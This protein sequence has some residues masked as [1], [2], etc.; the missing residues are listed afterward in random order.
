MPATKTAMGTRVRAYTRKAPTSIAPVPHRAAG[1]VAPGVLRRSTK[2]QPQDLRRSHVRVA[3]SKSWAI[4]EGI[5]VGLIGETGCEVL[6]LRRRRCGQ[7]I[8]LN[9]RIDGHMW[10]FVVVRVQTL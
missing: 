7:R 10:A 5:Q 8:H 6:E 3:C 9:Y 2:K 4:P 1:V